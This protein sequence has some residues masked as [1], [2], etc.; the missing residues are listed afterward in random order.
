[1]YWKPKTGNNF[2][3]YQKRSRAVHHHNATAGYFTALEYIHGNNLKASGF[4]GAE[5]EL[6]MSEWRFLAAPKN[7]PQSK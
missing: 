4:G 3:A 2:W 5:F 1:M 6:D 7:I